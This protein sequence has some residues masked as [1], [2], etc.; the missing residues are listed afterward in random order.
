MWI[1]ILCLGGYL[2]L[3]IILFIYVFK[4]ED[5]YREVEDLKDKVFMMEVSGNDPDR[6][7]DRHSSVRAMEDSQDPEV[8]Q[9]GACDRW[10]KDR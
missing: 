3:I 8:R 1:D 10:R 7:P 5:L 2:G 4:C 9:H 6:N